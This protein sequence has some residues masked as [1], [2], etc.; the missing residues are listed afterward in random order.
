MKPARGKSAV[1]LAAVFV[2]GI[3][4]LPPEGRPTGMF[5]APVVRALEVGVEGL[6]GDAQADR[7]VHGGPEKAVHHY[8]AENYR[9]LAAAFPHRAEILAP[10][11]LGENLSSHGLTE[12]RVCIGDVLRI[13][14][15]VLQVSQPRRPCWKIDHRLDAPGVAQHVGQHG[16]TGWYYRV[17]APG[18]LGASDTI[19]QLERNAQPVTLA[20]LWAAYM[21]ARPAL[22]E[23]DFLCRT[24]GLAPG[25]VR[26]LTERME[27]LRRNA[28]R[29][30]QPAPPTPASPPR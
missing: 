27:W 22:D 30:A 11:V 12:D 14:R 10:G 2:G 29:C 13:G 21:A 23:L 24:P 6:A 1:R 9:R 17:L 18:T 3:R 8:P 26:S 4:P 25:W 15:C 20:R 28:T 16:L 19:E 7:R 5:K